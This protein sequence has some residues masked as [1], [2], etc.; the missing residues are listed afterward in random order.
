ME[1]KF[2]LVYL[3][4]TLVGHWSTLIT[5]AHEEWTPFNVDRVLSVTRGGELDLRKAIS[6]RRSE[7]VTEDCI[8]QFVATDVCGQVSPSRF[9]CNRQSGSILYQHLG[10]L[11]ERELATF[12]VS[13]PVETP[14]ANVSIFSVEIMIEAPPAPTSEITLEQL[15]SDQILSASVLDDAESYN[16]KIVFPAELIGTCHYEVVTDWPGL[17]LPVSGTVMGVV[18][19]PLPCGFMDSKGLTYIPRNFSSISQLAEDHLLIKVHFY[20]KRVQ[21]RFIVLPLDLRGLENNSNSS[22]VEVL[23]TQEVVIH[24]GTNTP[25][26]LLLL[27]FTRS[28]SLQLNNFQSLYRFT[29]PILSAGSFQSSLTSVVNTTHTTFTNRDLL[30]GSVAFYP[31]FSAPER[32]L[33]Q[34]TIANLAGVV[35]AMGDVN[36]CVRGHQWEWPVQRTNRPLKVWQGA[37]SILDQRVFDFYLQTDLC[38]Q[39]ATMTVLV[40]PVHGHLTFIN[41][42]D[43]DGTSILIS[44]VKNGT[45]LVYSH[46]NT[47]KGLTDSIIWEVRC[48]GGPA[49]QVFTSVLI[50]PGDDTP[51]RILRG[52]DIKVHRSW[53]T[54]ISPSSVITFDLDSSLDDISVSLSDE[55]QVVT[56]DPT[57]LNIKEKSYLFP[58]VDTKHLRTQKIIKE[59]SHISLSE[60][61]DYKVWYVPPSN[62]SVTRE[63]LNFSVGDS[64][65]TV[66]VDIFD[67]SLNQSLHLTT[68]EERPYVHLNKPLPL[69]TRTGT[70]ITSS[71]LYSQAPQ[72]SPDQVVY[73]ITSPPSKGLL[74]LLSGEKCQSSV[75]QFTQRDINTQHVYYEPDVG[76]EGIKE[77]S[78]EFKVMIDEFQQHTITLHQFY[79]KPV[80]ERVKVATDRTFYVT[81][82]GSKAIAPRHF[83]PYSQYFNTRDLVF[84]ITRRPHYGHLEL[85]GQPNPSNFS[86]DDLLGTRELVYRHLVSASE[87]CSDHFSFSVGNTT[88]LLDGTM[89]IAIR[90]GRENVDVQVDVGHHT[91]FSDQRKFVFGS[92]DISVSSSFCLDFVTFTLTSLP[93]FGVLSL[94]DN[95]HNTIIQLKENSTFTANDI[96]SG[97]LHYTFTHLMQ[98]RNQTLDKFALNASDPISKWTVIDDRTG[99][100]TRHFQVIIIPSPNIKHELAIDITSPGFLTWLPSYERYGYIFSE[101]DIT[102]FNSTIEERQVVIQIDREP[103]FGTIWK[104][105]SMDNIFTVEDVNNGLVWYRSDVRLD[106][107]LSDSFQMSIIVNLINFSMLVQRDEFVINWATVQLK[108]NS[109]RVTESNGRVEIIVR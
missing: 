70:Y 81:V 93:S 68:L 57:K 102:I 89:T 105:N 16:Y 41:G 78:F 6:L 92:E 98:V 26:S 64:M 5:A 28:S 61:E 14:S 66:A 107:F 44:A 97:F 7:A 37:S 108:D 96:Y 101:N 65:D 30:K 94:V 76:E 74:C 80:E 82:G 11:A 13:S 48:P 73:R 49:L 69:H 17:P 12:I 21:N 35:V 84:E 53:A 19:Q 77:D 22:A 85:R 50:A 38:I 72:Y 75:G 8:V 106:G 51:D 3:W 71:Y 32:T 31:S 24:Q 20:E 60:L 67:L 45:V 87:A 10:C 34:Y 86:F 47:S 40:P 88:H 9:S 39:R 95:E 23:P 36:V 90:H 52:G 1:M 29:F 25:I 42:S 99:P 104:S 15:E 79:F 55:G 109:L 56:F 63:L 18:N 4:C 43:V 33:F 83:R 100:T 2:C 27:T 103:E 62:L 54:P 46:S 59:V 58:F 91:L